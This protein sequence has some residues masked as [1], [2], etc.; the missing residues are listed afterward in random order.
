MPRAHTDRKHLAYTHQSK[1]AADLSRSAAPFRAPFRAP[2]LQRHRMWRKQWDWSRRQWGVQPAAIKG[3]RGHRKRVYA[4]GGTPGLEW[5]ECQRQPAIASKLFV[6]EPLQGIRR[7]GTRLPSSRPPSFCSQFL[8]SLVSYFSMLFPCTS[9]TPS[10]QESHGCGGG[11]GRHHHAW[12]MLQEMN[13]S[14]L[15]IHWM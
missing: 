5:L 7:S 9:S 8:N 2:P 11:T 12:P 4:F 1:Q 13:G 6:R 15:F 3:V 10:D 14:P